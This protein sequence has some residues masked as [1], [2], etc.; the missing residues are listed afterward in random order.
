MDIDA[1]P[2]GLPRMHASPFSA[3]PRASA[4]TPRPG[5]IAALGKLMV[6]LRPRIGKV[7]PEVWW[8]VLF[9][10]LLFA[11]GLTLVFQPTVGRGGR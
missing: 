3:D 6:G 4:G 1:G 9:A 5:R 8:L 10:C 7:R 11:F 2:D